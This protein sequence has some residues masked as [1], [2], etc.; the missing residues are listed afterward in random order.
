MK[1][2]IL[3]RLKRKILLFRLILKATSLTLKV[4]ILALFLSLKNAE[5][6]I[7]KKLKGLTM[8]KLT[9]NCQEKEKENGK[10]DTL[11]EFPAEEN[12]TAGLSSTDDT[13]AEF[14]SDIASV[15]FEIWHIL[16]PEVSELSDLEK[17]AIGKPLARIVLKYNLQDYAKD[18][19]YL[20]MIFSG[21]L[22]KRIK[23]AKK[24]VNN[25]NRK[26]GDG[27]DDAGEKSDAENKS[28]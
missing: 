19:I 22:F 6:K 2:K 15:P 12:Q 14:C 10:D 5:E 25:N 9:L 17:K 24:N 27:K 1:L 11:P 26:K 16:K 20:T 18:E 13:L 28:G 21:V 23:Q 7:K 8:K 3:K 4:L